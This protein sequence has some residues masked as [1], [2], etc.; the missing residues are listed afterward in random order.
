MEKK[1]IKKEQYYI[2]W[3][4][5]KRY[6]ANIDQ[7]EVE[8]LLLNEIRDRILNNEYYEPEEEF[9]PE[10]TLKQLVNYSLDTFL[11]EF[12][13]KRKETKEWRKFPDTHIDI[14]FIESGTMTEAEEE[15]GKISDKLMEEIK[16]KSDIVK[17]VSE[18]VKLKPAGKGFKGMCPFC[19]SKSNGFMVSPSKQLFHCFDCGEGA[20]IFGFIMKIKKINFFETIKIL[21]KKAGIEI[22]RE[23]EARITDQDEGLFD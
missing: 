11:K 10:I 14:K 16:D 19:K 2:V 5:T 7:S 8:K 15:E 9:D 23:M 3:T 6:S 18:Y 22:P 21:A 17:I 12:P 13:I 4:H 1:R 20:N